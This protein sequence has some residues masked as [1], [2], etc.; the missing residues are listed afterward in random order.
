[1]V[2]KGEIRFDAIGFNYG[3]AKGTPGSDPTRVI[4]GL[5]LTIRAGEKIGLIGPE[6]RR[7]SACSCA[8]TILRRAAF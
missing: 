7:S 8:S 2:R 6:N 5:S 1:V 4:D 3:S